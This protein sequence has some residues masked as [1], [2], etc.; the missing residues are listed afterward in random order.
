M[1]S[2]ASRNAVERN[3]ERLRPIGLGL[4]NLGALLMASGL[5]RKRETRAA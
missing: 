3:S 2:T 5:L 4:A 1:P